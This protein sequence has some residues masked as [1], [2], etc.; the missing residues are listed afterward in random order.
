MNIVNVRRRLGA[1]CAAAG[2]P[3]DRGYARLM[4]AFTMVNLKK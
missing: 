1:F 2:L 4:L 3:M